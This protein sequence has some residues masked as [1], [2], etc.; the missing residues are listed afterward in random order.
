[1]RTRVHI[2]I[3]KK[4]GNTSILYRRVGT[5][6]TRLNPFSVGVPQKKRSFCGS[7]GVELRAKVN[8]FARPRLP[9]R[10]SPLTSHTDVVAD[11]S[12]RTNYIPLNVGIGTCLDVGA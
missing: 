2:G 9:N 5:T 6:P 12:Q 1:M 7:L 8:V 3:Q 10:R 4:A 11:H